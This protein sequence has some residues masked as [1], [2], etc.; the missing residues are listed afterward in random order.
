MESISSSR[1]SYRPIPTSS[2]VLIGEFKQP[3]IL[4]NEASLICWNN[5]MASKP[6]LK[7]NNRKQK[8]TADGFCG[9]YY[10]QMGKEVLGRSRGSR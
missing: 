6:Q 2:D 10:G 9:T 1:T 7:K 4:I 3:L 5:C 8:H